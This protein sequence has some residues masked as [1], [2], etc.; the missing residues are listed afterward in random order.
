MRIGYLCEFS[1]VI[2]RPPMPTDWNSH[3]LA[4]KIADFRRKRLTPFL[5]ADTERLQSY[6]LSLVA[7]REYPPARG[8]GIDWLAISESCEIAHSRLVEI[9]EEI[10]PA[11]DAIVRA[12]DAAARKEL[13]P[14]V[15]I[16]AG[17]DNDAEPSRPEKQP[18]PI[19]S[20]RILPDLSKAR[21]YSAEPGRSR[22][23]LKR[24]AKPK[25]VEQFPEPIHGLWDDPATFREALML[26]MQRHG[27]T[28]WHLHRA[29][30]DPDESFDIKTIRSWV[31]G[32]R[33][34]ISVESREIL[35]RIERRYRLPEGY[36]QEKLPIRD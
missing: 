13:E 11:L 18:K 9:K 31:R 15:R 30:V 10:R 22:P 24:G 3:I 4:N 20:A 23:K 14:R 26:H 2:A 25:P 28:Y 35:R 21:A 8:R 1:N 6:L 5:H 27:E 17:N 12:L 36:F 32:T 7:H 16:E 33:A 34:P 19:G 29:I